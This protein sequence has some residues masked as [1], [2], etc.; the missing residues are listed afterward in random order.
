MLNDIIKCQNTGSQLVIYQNK[1]SSMVKYKQDSKP[2]V[3][4][5]IFGRFY[6]KLDKPLFL[7]FLS[8]SQFKTGNVDV[9]LNYINKY[10]SNVYNLYSYRQKLFIYFK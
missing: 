9:N 2:P 10:N 6:W 7:N 1:I 8:F 4:D 5:P 3:P